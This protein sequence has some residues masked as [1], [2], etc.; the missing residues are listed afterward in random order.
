MTPLLAK[1]DAADVYNLD[2]AALFYK[3]LPTKTFAV[4]EA[5]IKGRKQNKDRITVLFGANMCDEHKLPLLVVGKTEK[6]RCFKNARLPPKD[7]L[8]YKN[9][10]KA[11]MTAAIL[12][13]YVRQLD[14]KFAAAGRNVLFV[15]DNCPAHGDIQ[16]LQAI[17]LVF[18]PPNTTSLSQP[19]DQGVILHTRKIYRYNLLKRMLLCYDNG[20]EYAIDLLGAIWLIVH[21]W[22]QVEATV[23]L[24]CF[25]HAGFVKEVA[26]S[27]D[28]AV[29][30]PFDEEGETLCALHTEDGECSTIGFSDYSNIESTVPTCYTDLDSEIAAR[31]TDSATNAEDSDDEPARVPPLAEVINA[32]CVARSFV[33]CNGG[34][35]EMLRLVDRLEN[36]TFSATNYRKR[37]PRIEEFIS[38]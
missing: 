2:E 15:I 28:C 13:E 24:R 37:Q 29:T 5:D 18:L 12:E 10:K 33:E 4:K 23:I 38:K 1:Y 8:I 34:E 27:T 22:R 35:A 19:M 32:L 16:N 36:M 25:E 9:N 20:K 11:W 26:T 6:P 14:R 21:A 31:T 3:M 17:K 7:D 30:C